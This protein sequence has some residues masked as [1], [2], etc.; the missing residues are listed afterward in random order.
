MTALST[1]TL[2]ALHAAARRHGYDH[3]QLR[4][5]AGVASLK[6]LSAAD[7]SHLLERLN[8]GTPRLSEHPGS[9]Q[10]HKRKRRQKGAIGLMTHAQRWKIESLR[11]QMSMTCE[12]FNNWLSQRHLSDGRA[13]TQANTTRDG[14]EV[15]E[16]LKGVIARKNST[17][18]ARG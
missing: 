4:G 9:A 13:M 6:Q 18:E 1:Q 7:A 16:L 11:C 14:A 8:H 10:A 3:E 5:L 2:R 17:P 12:Q 15:I